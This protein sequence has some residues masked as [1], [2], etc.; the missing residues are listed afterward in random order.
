[1]ILHSYGHDMVILKNVCFINL[2]K[3]TIYG[4]IQKLRVLSIFLRIAS[5]KQF[6]KLRVLSIIKHA[7]LSD[8][9]KLKKLRVLSVY[10]R[11]ASIALIASIASIACFITSQRKLN[12]IVKVVK[13][14]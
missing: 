4:H 5:S 3:H 12:L 13:C 8:R 7:I 11:I 6:S 14:F 9:K 2:L 10:L 1:M